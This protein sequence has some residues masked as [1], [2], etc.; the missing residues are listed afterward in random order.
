MAQ[1][2]EVNGQTIEF[3]DGMPVGEIEAAIKKNM[4]SIPAA[5]PQSVRAG[6]VLTCKHSPNPD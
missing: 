5:K 2:I 3:P 1:L 6:N 4:L